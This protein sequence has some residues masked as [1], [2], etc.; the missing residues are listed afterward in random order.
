MLLIISDDSPIN[1]VALQRGVVE[2][3]EL[4]FEYCSKQ[5]AVATDLEDP[6]PLLLCKPPIFQQL[7]VI[8]TH[9][10]TILQCARS[11][12]KGQAISDLVL[13]TIPMS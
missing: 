12:A 5:H 7:K 11:H 9:L 3:G 13:P 10:P 8:A 1:L 4:H 2:R 6:T